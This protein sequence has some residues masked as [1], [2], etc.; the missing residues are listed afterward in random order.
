MR[1]PLRSGSRAGAL[2]VSPL[3]LAIVIIIISVGVIVAGP[4]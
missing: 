2:V 3:A 1:S 4:A